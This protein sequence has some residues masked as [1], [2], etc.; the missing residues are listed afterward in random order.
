MGGW[1][2][3]NPESPRQRLESD[4]GTRQLDRGLEV[5]RESMQ[6][7]RL[8]LT[9]GL[10]CELHR[11]AMTGVIGDPGVL[12]ERDVTITGSRHAPP[13]ARDV[14]SL[15]QT[16][17]AYVNAEP[18]DAIH[19]A[20]YIL[21]RINWIHPFA[22]DGNGRTARMTAF[23]LLHA[24]LNRM[25]VAKAGHPTLLDLLSSKRFDYTEA[26]EAADSA[27][28]TGHLNV[29]MMETLLLEIVEA[30]HQP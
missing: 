8:E 6:S 22:P 4:N 13:P 25:P 3:D 2:H 29:S 17:C 21:W 1:D 28:E 9:V 26:L 12:R 7:G 27:W 23:V 20:A 30:A 19:Q 10:V 15:L 5:I 14:P 24:R 16:A 18:G 11:I